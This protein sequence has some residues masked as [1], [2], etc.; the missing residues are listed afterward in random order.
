MG[1]GG[2]LA[3]AARVGVVLQDDLAVQVVGDQNVTPL[4]TWAAFSSAMARRSMSSRV[5]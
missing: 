1:G 5:V 2:Q 4:N 3:L